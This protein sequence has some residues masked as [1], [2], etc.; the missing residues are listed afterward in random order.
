[1]ELVYNATSLLSGLIP[2]IGQIN[3]M[4]PVIAP[5][6]HAYFDVF[7]GV[8]QTYIFIMLTTVLAK[9]KSE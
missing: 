2:V 3:F 7:A 6:L 1:M 4:G 9:S 8:L 5:A